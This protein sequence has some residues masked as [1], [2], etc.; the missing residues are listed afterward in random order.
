MAEFLPER[1]RDFRNGVNS[2]AIEA[3]FQNNTLNPV[4]QILPNISIV[5]IEV[6][7][8]SQPAIF[9]LKLVVPVIDVTVGMIVVLL[10]ERVDSGKVVANWADMVGNY[11]HHDPNS[12]RMSRVNQVFQCV[13]VSEIAIHFFEVAGPIAMVAVIYVLYK[14]SNPNCIEPQVLYILQVVCDSGPAPPAIVRQIAG[15]A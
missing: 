8:S 5:L 7:K 10:V 14:R 1:F 12:H 3:I 4:F 15:S 2:N 13:F 11:I 6:W 9:N